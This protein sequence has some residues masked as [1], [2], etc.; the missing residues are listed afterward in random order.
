MKKNNVVKEHV[1]VMLVRLL[2]GFVVNLCLQHGMMV[3]VL[4]TINLEVKILYN[5]DFYR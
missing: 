2:F 4:R 1:T 5:Q 3:K